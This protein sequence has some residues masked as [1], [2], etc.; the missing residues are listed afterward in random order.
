MFCLPKTAWPPTSHNYINRNMRT[1]LLLGAVALAAFVSSSLA[2]VYSLNVVGYYNVTVPGGGAFYF[3][4]NQLKAGN[5]TIKEVLPPSTDL[6]NNGVVVMVYDPPTGKFQE[7]VT[8]GTDWFDNVSGNPTSSTTSLPPGK[9]FFF[10]NGGSGFTQTF[11]G[12]VMQG[13]LSLS[14]TPGLNAIASQTPQQLDLAGNGFPQ[15]TELKLYFHSSTTGRY[16]FYVT[17]GSGTWFNDTTGDPT[18]LTPAVG[19]G[20]FAE[21]VGSSTLTWARTFTVQ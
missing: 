17:D 15:S 2:Q 18:T 13:A 20:I 10:N 1:K 3:A 7:N 16:S 9:S 4:A 11:V 8:D 14:M 6:A 19:Q 21:N 12:E 5:N